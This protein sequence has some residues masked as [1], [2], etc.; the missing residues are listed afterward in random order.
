MRAARL[1]SVTLGEVHRDGGQ[2]EGRYE[3]QDP[4]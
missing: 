3:V 1:G 2:Q 4:R